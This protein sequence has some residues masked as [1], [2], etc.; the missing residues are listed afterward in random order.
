MDIRAHTRTHVRMHARTRTRAHTHTHTFL[1]ILVWVLFL[2]ISIHICYSLTITNFSYNRS[3]SPLLHFRSSSSNTIIRVPSESTAF[4]CPSLA[5]LSRL[6]QRSVI[7]L[8]NA[9]D[10]ATYNPL[11]RS[12]ADLSPDTVGLFSRGSAA[13]RSVGKQESNKD[14][15]ESI[16]S[17]LYPRVAADV[18][19]RQGSFCKCADFLCIVFVYEWKVR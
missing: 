1:I 16:S 14:L 13:L 10:L 12:P 3:S 15:N 8:L 18:L 7:I 4:P 19:A 5:L 6:G 2:S 11:G 17:D 9:P